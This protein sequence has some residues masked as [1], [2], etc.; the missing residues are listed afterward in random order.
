MLKESLAGRVQ[1]LDQAE[2]WKKAVEMV[3]RPLQK[4]GVVEERYLQ[5]IYDNVAANGDYFIVM[6]G[7]AMPHSRP[8]NG[9]LK[10]GLSFLKLRKPVTFSSGQEVRYLMGIAS[11]DADSHVDTL[12]ELVDV[13]MDEGSMEKIEKAENAEELMEI[14][15]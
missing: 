6:P 12:A 9:A 8:E 13:L 3:I 1:I 11:K 14:F 5:A 7:F 10:G 15:G 4:D 2:D